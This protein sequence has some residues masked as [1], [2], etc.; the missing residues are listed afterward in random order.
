MCLDFLIV[1]CTC[2]CSCS[3]ISTY[4]LEYLFIIYP[5]CEMGLAIGGDRAVGIVDFSNL[6]FAATQQPWSDVK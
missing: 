4:Y 6:E 3:D 2:V 1:S 5:G